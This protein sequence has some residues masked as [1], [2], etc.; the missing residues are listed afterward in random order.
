MT[1]KIYT[2]SLIIASNINT[3]LEYQRKP[4]TIEILLSKPPPNLE[5]Y[6]DNDILKR[7]I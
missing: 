1:E 4:S 6:T 7:A 2:H 3:H 5:N